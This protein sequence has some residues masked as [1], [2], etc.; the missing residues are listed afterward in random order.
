MNWLKSGAMILVLAM[1]SYAASAPPEA[2]FG[3]PL[4]SPAAAAT[5]Q[6]GPLG[7]AFPVA[8]ARQARQGTGS[9]DRYSSA[10]GELRPD[11]RTATR[12][13]RD[14]EVYQKA[15]P[16][17]VLVVSE[18]GLGSGVL[19]SADG[20]I[21]TNLHVV[22]ESSEVGVIFKPATEGAKIGKA[23]LRMAKVIKRDGLADLALLQVESPPVGAT[24]LAIGDVSSLRVGADVHAI[25]HPDGRQWTYTRGIVSQI[26]RDYEWS[27]E[28]G[29]AHKATVVQTQTP[30]NPGN[31]GGPLI[32]DDLRVVGIN[33]FVAGG[34]G[35]NFAVSGDDVKA[36][37]A[38]DGDRQAA[39]VAADEDSAAVCEPALVREWRD[40]DPPANVS[41]VDLDCD[42][43]GD[44][45]F[46]EPDDEAEPAFVVVD[47]DGDGAADTILYD[48]DRDGNPET[49]L[50][51]TD[52]VPGPDLI[53]FFREG[54]DEPYRWE[55]Y[56]EEEAAEQE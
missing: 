27:V 43:L 41:L 45:A 51:D 49:A 7:K 26:R 54:E 14:A 32:D 50:Y 46:Y 25:G 47:E 42:G 13:P 11:G 2:L 53:G 17:V 35:L 1:P 16:S 20:R 9:L 52:D 33:S 21:V 56:E 24:P 4:S 34:E 48:E 55:R 22:G 40:T 36:F 15:S 8:P 37:L 44:A 5:G 10:L 30:I 31:S 29:Q 23:D 38:R 18:A 12:G 39:P 28:P 19:V 3:A 6:A